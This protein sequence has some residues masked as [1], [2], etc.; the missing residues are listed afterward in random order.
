MIADVLNLKEQPNL[1][2]EDQK[3]E[4]LLIAWY[5]GSSLSENLHG[6]SVDEQTVF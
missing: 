6:Y 1:P 4:F 3:V 5:S 2:A